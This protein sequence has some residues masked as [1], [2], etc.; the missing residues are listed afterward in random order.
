MSGRRIALVTGGTR[1]IG[2]GIARALA[3]EGLDLVLGGRRPREEVLPVLEEL[4]ATGV[5]VD[6]AAGDVGERESREGLMAAVRE[7]FGR[8]NHRDLDRVEVNMTVTELSS[9]RQSWSGEFLSRSADG[10][11]PNERLALTLDNGQKGAARVS[12]TRFDSR[13]PDATIVHFTGTGPLG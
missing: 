10:I 9:G 6:Y 8:L 4:E 11:L 7:R 13:T 12:E 1:G 3:A 5:A 2:L